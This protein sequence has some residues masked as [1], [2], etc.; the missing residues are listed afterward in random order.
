MDWLVFKEM[1][2]EQ[3]LDGREQTRRWFKRLTRGAWAQF[4]SDGCERWL[5]SGYVWKCYCWDLLTGCV[6]G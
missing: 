2:P 6:S 1:T 3:S 5:D 4:G